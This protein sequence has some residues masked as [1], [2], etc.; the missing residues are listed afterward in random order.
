MNDN[1]AVI[2][3]KRDFDKFICGD[4]QHGKFDLSQ[5]IGSDDSSLGNI[6]SGTAMSVKSLLGM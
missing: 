4:R 6:T 3:M 2:R 1:T 5:S